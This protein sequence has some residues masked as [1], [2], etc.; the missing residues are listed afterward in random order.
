[1]VSRASSAAIDVAIIGAGP[2]GLTAGYALTRKGASVAVL[3]ANPER[4]GGISRTEEYRG[5]LFDVGGH[6]FF[7]KAREVE[8]L[9]SE[10]LGDDLI[11]RPRSSRILYRG[12]LFDYPL[13]P[14]QA[15]LSLGPVT[16]VACLLSYLVAHL[17]PRREPANF[18]EAVSDLFGKR[19]YEIFFKSYTEKV[20]G[21]DCREISAD[22]AR[23][24][25][26]GLSLRKAL[27]NALWLARRPTGGARDQSLATLITSFR[28]PRRGPGMLWEACAVKVEEA[29]GSVELG[30]RV[31]SLARSGDLWQVAHEG[32]GDDRRELQARHVISS[33]AIGDLIG[34]IRPPLDDATRNAAAG[35]RH[36]D[37][38]T[39]ALIVEDRGAFSDQWLY[40][41]DPRVR[42]GR[43][44]NFKMWSPWMVPDPAT[45][46]YGLEYFCFQDDDIWRLDDQSL[47]RIASEEL[48]TLGLVRPGDIRDGTVVRQPRAYPIYD[49]GYAGRV[50]AIR[51]ALEA[52]CPN[53]WTV[54]RN[55]MHRYN[56]Q[57][58]SMVT[59]L[60]TVENILAGTMRYDPWRVNEDAMYHEEGRAA[61]ESVAESPERG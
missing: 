18:E 7:S 5:Y 6:R 14:V 35:L 61:T 24:R 28:Y 47:I 4:V 9:W 49:E 57:D 46:C 48:T 38:L 27:T 23:Q 30:R 50:A 55:G 53:L 22:W 31:V 25:I 19:L 1:M 10:I 8:E 42:V 37:F 15:F 45:T 11:E 40:V 32:E 12:E 51:R 34:M 58:H 17:R 39:V 33:A 21:L 52:C 20:W 29:G 44:Q 36:R 60:L 59:A 56:N 3:E 54:G 16:S 13:K 26:R 43:I 2:A 41:H